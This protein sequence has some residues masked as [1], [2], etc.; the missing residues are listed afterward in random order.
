M[1]DARLSLCLVVPESQHLVL[2]ARGPCY[3]HMI[4]TVAQV[5]I[6]ALCV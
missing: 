3:T 5:L 2:R 6:T 4:G 1:T